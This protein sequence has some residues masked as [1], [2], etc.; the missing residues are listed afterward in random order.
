M[1]LLTRS[2]N[3]FNLNKLKYRL[4]GWTNNRYRK[5]FP[6]ISL[7]ILT[8]DVFIEVELYWN[9]II[10]EHFSIWIPIKPFHTSS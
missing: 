4:E 6:I 2:I 9:Y 8:D 10:S 5:S 3:K 7:G 1:D